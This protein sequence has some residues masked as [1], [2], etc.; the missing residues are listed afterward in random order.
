MVVHEDGEVIAKKFFAFV[1]R[2]NLWDLVPSVLSALAN[3]SDS[4]EAFET[5]MVRVPK[6]LSEENEGKIREIVGASKDARLKVEIDR[7]V[8]GGFVANYRGFEHEGSFERV[9]NRLAKSIK[10]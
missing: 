9:V 5:I 8:L 10:E 2:Y 6:T 7:K 1:E 4:S 3:S